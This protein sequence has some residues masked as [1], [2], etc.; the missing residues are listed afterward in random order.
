MREEMRE[1]N[2]TKRKKGGKVTCSA[3]ILICVRAATNCDSF[4]S[5][6]AL[7]STPLLPTSVPVLTPVPVH[8]PIVVLD[9]RTLRSD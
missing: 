4:S 1:A 9:A 3:M 6:I 5:N 8:V 7:F 2:T